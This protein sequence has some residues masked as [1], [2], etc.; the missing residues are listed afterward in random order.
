MLPRRDTS[1][2]YRWEISEENLRDVL[3]PNIG[4]VT[5]LVLLLSLKS[6]QLSSLE[7]TE[8]LLGSNFDL[9]PMWNT[10]WVD[11]PSLEGGKKS[12]PIWSCCRLYCQNGKVCLRHGFEQRLL[13]G[14]VKCVLGRENTQCCLPKVHIK[15]F[16]WY[17]SPIYSKNR[18]A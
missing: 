5:E 7:P 18:H 16:P 9:I 4:F 12:F 6:D 14:V 15:S 17:H 13:Y 1:E 10:K 2:S 11:S 8:N 3:Q